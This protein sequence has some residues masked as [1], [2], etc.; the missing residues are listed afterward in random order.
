MNTRLILVGLAAGL[1]LAACSK[2]AAP[3]PRAAEAGKDYRQ[4][5]VRSRSRQVVQ[6]NQMAVQ[7]AL[8]KFQVDLARFATNLGELVR[9]KYMDEIPALPEDLTYSYDPVMG[10]L[11]IVKIPPPGATPKPAQP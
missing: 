9:L 4:M 5:L 2:R 6:V 11:Q 10:G 3:P 1:A 8:Q 7:T